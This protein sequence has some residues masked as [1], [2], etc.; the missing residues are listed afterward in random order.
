MYEE[1]RRVV[2]E[3]FDRYHRQRQALDAIILSAEAC[4]SSNDRISPNTDA[5]PWEVERGTRFSLRFPDPHRTILVFGVGDALNHFARDQ[6]NLPPS[7][8][9]TLLFLSPTWIS[10]AHVQQKIQK[11]VQTPL[12]ASRFRDPNER[13]RLSARLPS[14]CGHGLHR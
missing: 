3:S 6:S 14:K 9:G 2:E 11:I 1:D 5:S 8:L 10:C 12:K 4:S 13:R 7:I